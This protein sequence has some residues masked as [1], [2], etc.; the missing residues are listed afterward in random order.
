MSILRCEGGFYR[1][2]LETE[3]NELYPRFWNSGN[4]EVVPRDG[5]KLR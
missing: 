5:T 4:V 1:T 2:A 3:S